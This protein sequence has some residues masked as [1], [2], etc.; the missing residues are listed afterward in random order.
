VYGKYH[1]SQY[2]IRGNHVAI[3]DA[4]RAGPQV[5]VRMDSEDAAVMI[6]TAG[7]G[8]TEDKKMEE[9]QKQLTIA[10]QTAAEQ[11]ARADT[12]E[13]RLAE[14]TSRIDVAEALAIG[15]KARADAAEKVRNDAAA[16][17]DAAV[18]TRVALIATASKVMRNDDVSTLSNR[19]IKIAM[20]KRIDN[21]TVEDSRSDEFVDALYMSAST[22]ADTAS[23]TLGTLRTGL[24]DNRQD[25]GLDPEIVAMRKM[26][27]DNAALSRQ[28]V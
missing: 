18:S 2:N 20:I 28:G 24:Q 7:R 12:A 4:G 16:G 25:A 14:A 3:V 23:N 1:V 19:A 13:V 17:F 26:M 8:I 21:I 6:S 15:E 22:R 9:L 10:L 5:R 11:R 27:A